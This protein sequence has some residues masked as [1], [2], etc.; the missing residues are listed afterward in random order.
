MKLSPFSQK[1]KVLQYENIPCLTFKMVSDIL[2]PP[3]LSLSITKR[4]RTKLNIFFCRRRIWLESTFALTLYEPWEKVIVDQ[5]FFSVLHL[6]CCVLSNVVTIFVIISIA[7]LVGLLKYLR[8][9]R[10]LSVMQRC[11][12]YYLWGSEEV[13]AGRRVPFPK[14]SL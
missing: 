8:V 12:I 3:R 2:Q 11:A 1:Q 7:I 13:V 6:T 14:K 9:P 4:P 5:P 10:H